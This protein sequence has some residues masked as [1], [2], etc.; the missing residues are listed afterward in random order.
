MP[1]GAH[2]GNGAF[3]NHH[4]IGETHAE[5]EAAAR[6]AGEEDDEPEEPEDPFEGLTT[7]EIAALKAQMGEKPAIDKPYAEMTGKEKAYMTFEDPGLTPLAGLISLVITCMI[8][9]STACFI[10]ETMPE[11]NYVETV[12]DTCESPPCGVHTD[13]WN[14][15]EL[16]VPPAIRLF[17]CGHACV[18]PF[19][20]AHTCCVHATFVHTGF[21][22][23][24]SPLTLSSSFRAPRSS[25][26]SCRTR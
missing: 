8:L 19:C 23:L 6:R 7:K 9:V 12:T 26:C 20:N 14:L 22:W 4:G 18:A 3:E 16:C 2:S 21:A 25:G 13:T 5:H 10:A 17:I 15:I 24:A 1:V 11:L